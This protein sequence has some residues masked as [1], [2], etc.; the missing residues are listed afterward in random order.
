M[1]NSFALMKKFDAD[2]L[3]AK[4]LVSVTKVQHAVK[5]H[6]S[7][8]IFEPFVVRNQVSDNNLPNRANQARHALKSRRTLIVIVLTFSPIK[9][10][11]AI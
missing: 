1:R 3:C 4:P 10:S 2:L 5:L 8:A 9:S 6:F 11:H 7:C